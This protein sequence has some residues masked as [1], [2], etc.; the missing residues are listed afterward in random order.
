MGVASDSASLSRPGHL[1]SI[2]DLGRVGI[3]AILDRAEDPDH[4]PESNV[5]HA[6]L[7]S[8]IKAAI[9]TLPEQ[10]RTLLTRHYFDDVNLDEAAKEIG[11][12]KSW[13]S[14]LHARGIET[15]AKALKRTRI[16]V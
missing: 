4:S 14:R 10:E 12:S 11:L 5:G 9:A 15:V 16:E 2:A 7:L 13:A 1:L 3:L 8:R 6:E